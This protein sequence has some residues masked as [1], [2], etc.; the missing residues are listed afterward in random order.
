MTSGTGDQSRTG[1]GARALA[2]CAGLDAGLGWV[3]A[4]GVPP[5]LAVVAVAVALLVVGTGRPARY[6]PGRATPNPAA[7]RRAGLD[8]ATRW[9]LALTALAA[10]GAALAPPDTVSHPARTAWLTLALVAVLALLAEAALV[11]DARPPSPRATLA[12]ATGPQR[13]R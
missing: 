4:A 6:G 10:A 8:P 3:P 5:Q 11:T 7:P 9:A 12:T 2:V 13:H 1:R